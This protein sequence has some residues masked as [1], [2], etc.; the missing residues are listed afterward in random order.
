[1]RRLFSLSTAE[2]ETV[3]VNML[4]SIYQGHRQKIYRGEGQ[5]PQ[6]WWWLGDRE[7]ISGSSFV[8]IILFLN[9]FRKKLK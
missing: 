5:M 7:Y 6:F 3:K 2:N 1:M 9:T 8:G 4:L